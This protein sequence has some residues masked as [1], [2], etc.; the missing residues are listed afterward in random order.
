MTIGSKYIPL[1]YN[2]QRRKATINVQNFDNK[3]FK[4]NAL[5]RYVKTVTPHRLMHHY[6]DLSDKLYFFGLSFPAQLRQIVILE[7]KNSGVSI[8]IYG[9][10]KGKKTYKNNVKTASHQNPNQLIIISYKKCEIEQTYHFDLLLCSDNEGES[11]YYLITDFSRLVNSQYKQN[12]HAMK[13]CKRCFKGYEKLE[14]EELLQNYK[15]KCIKNKSATPCSHLR[16]L[17]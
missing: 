15:I 12:E 13:F 14:G 9:Y 8:N 11:H 3:C 6:E 7:K 4:Y 17:S 1:P 5:S 16:I 10:K 2:I